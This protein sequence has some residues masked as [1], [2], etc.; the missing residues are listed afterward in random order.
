MFFRKK[1]KIDELL[2]LQ[3]KNYNSIAECFEKNLPEGWKIVDLFVGCTDSIIKP[4]CRVL[5]DK[6]EWINLVKFCPNNYS[7]ILNKISLL[8]LE[9]QK[10]AKQRDGK[11]KW[12]S[13]RFEI[14]DEFKMECKYGYAPNK[15]TST[16]EQQQ[17]FCT[18]AF[19]EWKSNKEIPMSLFSGIE[20][21]IYQKVFY[22]IASYMPKDWQIIDFFVGC[23]ATSIKPNY[24][25]LTKENK[26][27]NCGQFSNREKFLQQFE[28]IANYVRKIWILTPKE[29]KWYTLNM[30]IDNQ[31]HMSASYGFADNVEKTEEKL[32][33][34]C[35][36]QFVQWKNKFT[37]N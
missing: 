18:E 26:W 9:E 31:R 23:T 6:Y 30:K 8:L 29:N 33:K 1:V 24:F 27:Y 4:V 21:E 25:V 28:I 10:I 13:F 14:N 3:T 34:Y 7:H 20:Q 16:E 12:N 19:N 35:D 32:K 15:E 36:A 37:N 22:T 11:G 17:L 2:D 5:T